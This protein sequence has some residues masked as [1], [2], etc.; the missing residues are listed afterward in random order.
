MYRSNA[1]IKILLLDITNI[2]ICK[3]KQGN[4]TF[5]LRDDFIFV[6]LQIPDDIV[7]DLAFINTID[8]LKTLINRI[9]EIPFKLI[10][11]RHPF[12]RSPEVSEILSNIDNENIFIFDGNIHDVIPYAKKI[13]TV[14]SGVGFEALLYKKEI[15]V[16][17]KCSYQQVATICQDEDDLMRKIKRS[18]S[19]VSDIEIENFL[20]LYFS[21]HVYHKDQEEKIESRII[22]YLRLNKLS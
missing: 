3:Y 14:N 9:N 6:P 21:E 19:P 12:C 15:I 22:E 11:K 16:T 4:K 5:S 20:G 18:A 13:L 2:L 17:G 1:S 7:A 10:I 8:L